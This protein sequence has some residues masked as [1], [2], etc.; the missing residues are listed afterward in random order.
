MSKHLIYQMLPRLWGE[1]K[2]SSVD[3]A[4]LA[5]VKSMG[6]DYIWYT[7]IVRH[8]TSATEKVVKGD[9]GSPYAITDWYDVNPYMATDPARRMEEFREL[10]RRTHEAG[11]KV[12][13]DF[14]PNHVAR[15][16]SGAMTPAGEPVLG[17]D[18][19]V[20]EH[21]SPDNDFYYYPGEALYM[22]YVDGYSE[23]PARAS[24]NAFTPAPSADDWYET[25]KLNYCNW[26]T[27]TWDKMLAV[28]RF[29][30]SAGVDGFRC[31]MVELVP[32]Q[33]MQ[34]AISTVKRD[35]PSLMFVAEVYEKDKYEM[36]VHEVGFDL[37][38]DKSGLYDTLR[39]IMC[40]GAPASGITA[41]W[42][43]LGALQPS[44]LC[45]LENHD[46]QRV[47]SDFFA[48][49]AS[50][51]YAA[52]AVSLLLNDSSFMLYFGQEIGERGMD[53][54]PFSGLNGRTTIFDWWQV[55]SLQRLRSWIDNHRCGLQPSERLVLKRYTSLLALASEPVFSEGLTYDLCYCQGPGFDR[56]RHFAFLRS[57]GSVTVL[58][59]TNFGPS[60]KI[61]V[62]IPAK[63][64]RFLDTPLDPRTLTLSVPS[65]DFVVVRL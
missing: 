28:L 31:D 48:G 29:W 65:N 14:V 58:V 8:A 18:D 21:W 26:R 22:P 61:T 56:S 60:A 40:S 41:N 15:E 9:A 47:A 33:F 52:V 19:D 35:Y 5:Y 50:A 4:F 12:L 63:A 23:F 16:Y 57:T 25:V 10:L 44:M 49:S 53:C 38:Y 17:A 46:E 59:I 2:F 45:F 13:I 7:G 27:P 55:A 42:Q 36:Y 34:W 20:N 3:S 54:E 62:Q 30:A 64:L 32:P 39:A 43:F 24:G 6:F 1:G 11:L 51:A 37:L